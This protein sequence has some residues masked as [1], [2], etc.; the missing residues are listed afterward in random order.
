MKK[1]RFRDHSLQADINGRVYTITGDLKKRRDVG[2]SLTEAARLLANGK[3]L[4]P[5][6]QAARFIQAFRDGLNGLLGEQAFEQ[7]FEGREENLSDMIDL[8][9]F[10]AGIMREGLPVED[11]PTEELLPD[12]FPEKTESNVPAEIPDAP[13]SAPAYPIDREALMKTLLET[14]NAHA[15]PAP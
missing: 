2:A 10:L 8:S 6:E 11:S 3:N 13:V 15:Q 14:V 9:H 7:I 1:F 5:E 12:R 4:S